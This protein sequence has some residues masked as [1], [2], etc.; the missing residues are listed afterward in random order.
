MAYLRDRFNANGYNIQIA[1][2][3]TWREIDVPTQSDLTL[4]LGHVGTLKSTIVLPEWTPA[5]PEIGVPPDG[6]TWSKANDIET[7]LEIIDAVITLMVNG[8]WY[9]GELYSGEAV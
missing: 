3:T 8:Y 2:K 6:L 5:V 1:P 9:S 4:Y 7:I